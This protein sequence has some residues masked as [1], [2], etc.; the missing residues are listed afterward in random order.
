MKEGFE[1]IF[2]DKLSYIERIA[3]HLDRLNG[4]IERLIEI[5]S[6]G[7]ETENPPWSPGVSPFVILSLTSND[8]PRLI[9]VEIGHH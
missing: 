9:V 3:E 2:V 7:K 6:E 1:R 4:N 5:V 8:S